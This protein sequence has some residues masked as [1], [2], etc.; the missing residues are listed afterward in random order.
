MAGNRAACFVALQR[1][2]L[3]LADAEEAAELMPQ[4]GKAL[5]RLGCCQADS[6]DPHGA[7]ASLTKAAQLMPHSAEV[8]ERQ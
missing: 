3:A 7:L 8:G 6:D 4:W 1:P 5:Y 2:D